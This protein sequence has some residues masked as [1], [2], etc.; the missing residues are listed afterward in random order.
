MAGNRNDDID[1]FKAILRRNVISRAREIDVPEM[2]GFRLSSS[3]DPNASF[4]R[5][6]LAASPPHPLFEES[7]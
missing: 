5:L 4:V 3:T 7:S 2:A 6:A 1:A